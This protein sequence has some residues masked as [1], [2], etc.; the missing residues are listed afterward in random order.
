VYDEEAAVV[1][2]E[3]LAQT[4]TTEEAMLE[5]IQDRFFR[6]LIWNKLYRRKILDGVRFPEE[7]GID[8]EFFTYQAIGKAGKLVHTD[9]VLYAYRQQGNSV[10]HTL[11]TQQRLQAVKAKAQRHAY[12][13]HHMP[14]LQ[15]M[16]GRSL[17]FTCLYQGQ[18]ALR[19]Q[20]SMH[21]KQTLD[22]LREVLRKNPILLNDAPVKD[23][24]WLR[25]AEAS[26]ETT[27]RL[28]NLLRIGM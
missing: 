24:L 7:K 11:N 17:W 22:F 4:Y 19:E 18:L 25:L 6:Q 26:L 28:R 14:Q 3:T 21:S 20:E 27:C 2:K 15:S 16:S 10:M 23:K 13:C 5:H 8:D 9:A 1:P 12:I